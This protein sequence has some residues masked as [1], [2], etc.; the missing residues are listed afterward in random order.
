[1]NPEDEREKVWRALH[2]NSDRITELEATVNTRNE[3]M[4]ESILSAVREAMP[5]ALLTDEQHRWLLMAI[6]ASAQRAMLR[7][8]ILESA[9]IWAVPLLLVA[10][11]TVFREYA[12]AHGMWS[13]S[14]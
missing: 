14:K 13:P 2:T 7:R 5:K 12:I 6:E 4:R 11:L 8:K 3:M 1:M 9:A 10:A